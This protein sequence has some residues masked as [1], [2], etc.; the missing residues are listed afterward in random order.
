MEVSR[1]LGLAPP[2]PDVEAFGGDRDS[3][4]GDA[5]SAFRITALVDDD[6][7]EDDPRVYRHPMCGG[8]LSTAGSFDNAA[9]NVLIVRVSSAG[10]ESSVGEPKKLDQYT[11]QIPVTRVNRPDFVHQLLPTASEHTRETRVG[12]TDELIRKTFGAH[13]DYNVLNA[14][15]QAM[16]P[17]QESWTI[18]ASVSQPYMFG[19]MKDTIMFRAPNAVDALALLPLELEEPLSEKAQVITFAADDAPA[20][21]P[22]E[23]PQ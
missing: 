20:P 3:G 9:K 10:L 19:N 15:F 11:V 13:F 6:A 23:R 1:S 7:M 21:A 8:V 2:L 17:E 22:H 4:G 16:V 18:E 14:A 12:S 5:G